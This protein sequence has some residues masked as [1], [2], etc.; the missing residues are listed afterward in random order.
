MVA[1]FVDGAE[2][3]EALGNRSI[4]IS[5]NSPLAKLKLNNSIKSRDFWMP[6]AL[7][8]LDKMEDIYFKKNKFSKSP[9]M[10]TCYDVKKGTKIY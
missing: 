3:G 8:A 5:P 9:Y 4:L 10:T 1:R 6:F 2:F 7:T